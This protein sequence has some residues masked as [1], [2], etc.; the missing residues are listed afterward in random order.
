M[1][2]TD[3]DCSGCA[4]LATSAVGSSSGGGVSP[5]RG[6]EQMNDGLGRSNCG[7]FHWIFNSS[8]PTTTCGIPPCEWIE[9]SWANPVSIA[10]MYI[11]TEPATGQSPCGLSNRNLAGG[12]VQYFSNNQWHDV[13]TLSGFTDDPRLDFGGPI[14]T[15]R[16][17]VSGVV[18]GAANVYN[19]VIYEWYVYTQP[20]CKP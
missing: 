5:T 16:L 14:T 19:S 17:R 4:N 13:A 18:T 3:P 7:G 6:P 10:S 1:P 15:N 11:E 2:A 12:T 9:L 20:G 8:V